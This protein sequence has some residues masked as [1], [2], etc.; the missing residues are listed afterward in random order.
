LPELASAVL[1][2]LIVA[3]LGV[4]WI[5]P[6][7]LWLAVCGIALTLADWSAH[8]LPDRLTLP[9]AI[10]LL[11]LLGAAAVADQDGTALVRA[12]GGALALGGFYLLAALF[13]NV[14]LGDVKLA[15][16]LGAVL[17]W[18]GWRYLIPGLLL[19]FLLGAAYGVA[20]LVTQRASGKHRIAFGPFMIAGTLTVCLLAGGCPPV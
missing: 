8:L 5:T 12:L 9:T 7:V 20:L 2:G 19:G 17:A 10:G 18:F 3:V 1:W 11:A 16:S 4:S 13:T 6:A 14:G 15:P